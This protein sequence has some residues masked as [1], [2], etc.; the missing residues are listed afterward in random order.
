MHLSPRCGAY[1]RTTGQ[2]CQ[3]P[4]IKGKA[5]CRMHGGKS[6]GRPKLHG[7]YSQAYMAQIQEWRR[8]M[9]GLKA[10]IQGSGNEAV[11][12]APY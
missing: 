9:R 11:Q 2:P 3:A 12:K 8:V 10:I 1:A 5:R 6:P 4:A 7:R